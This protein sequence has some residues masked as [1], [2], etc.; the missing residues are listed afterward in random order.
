[1]SLFLL[2]TICEI[3]LINLEKY[4]WAIWSVE[5]MSFGG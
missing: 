1:M 5:T 4:M 2:S 3:I